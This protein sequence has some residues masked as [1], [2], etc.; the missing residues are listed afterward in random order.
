MLP[1]PFFPGPFLLWGM[2]LLSTA[3]ADPTTSRFAPVDP[4]VQ[5][6]GRY[7]QVLHGD[8][9]WQIRRQVDRYRITCLAVKPAP[10]QPDP[11]LHA[12]LRIPFGG[13]GFYMIA[14]EDWL[15]PHFGFYGRHPYDRISMA[16]R[17]G[18]VIADVDDQERV[19][20]WEGQSIGY[21]VST[22]PRPGAVD[23]TQQQR[24]SLD[25][26]GVQAAFTALEDCLAG[27][28]RSVPAL[29]DRGDD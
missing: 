24:G 7:Q 6:A 29:I 20:G 3:C 27:P 17:N 25:F 11:E 5:Q 19:L 18:T 1:R 12:E 28:D 8:D 21:R 9:G 10:E 23:D 2:V 26:T 13:A 16:E 15:R 14:G 4:L 22:L